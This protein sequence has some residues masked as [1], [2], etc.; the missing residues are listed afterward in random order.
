MSLHPRS[1]STG[2]GGLERPTLEGSIAVRDGRRLSFAEYGTPRGRP[3]VWLH[4]TPGGR[5]QIPVEAREFALEAGIRIIGIDRPGIGTSTPH[6]YPDVLDWTDDLRLVLDA[7]AVDEFRVIGL[8][9]G[10]PYALAAGAALPH[11]TLGVGVLGGVAPTRGPDAAEGGPIQLAVRLA[12]ALT[13]VRVPLGVALTGAIRV[14]KPLAGPA[15]DL[16]AAVQPAG[17]KALLARPEFKAMFIDDLLN[18]SRFQISAPLADLV[19]FTRDWGFALGD[20]KAPVRW[21]HG[22]QD[23][24]VPFAH[25]VHAVSLLPDAALTVID[26]ESHLGGLGIARTVLE[27]MMGVG[28]TPGLGFDG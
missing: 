24:I 9:G 20:V 28:A 2:H 17:D 16:Y 27:A 1:T 8:S 10:G 11:R 5:R 19:L 12:P 3:L 18:G 7:L 14:V 21:W 23:H 26:G 4:G 25:G 22:G 6:L 15:L 13:A